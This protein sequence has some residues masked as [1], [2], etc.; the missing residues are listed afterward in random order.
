MLDSLFRIRDEIFECRLLDFTGIAL[1]F[2]CISRKQD[3]GAFLKNQ[4]A[5]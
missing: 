4:N 3:Q 1:F 5:K 2:L